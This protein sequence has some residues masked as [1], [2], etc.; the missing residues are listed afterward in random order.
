LISEPGRKPTSKQVQGAESRERIL[1]AAEALVAERG[2]AATSISDVVKASRLPSSSIYWHFSSKEELLGAVVERGAR[3]WLREVPAWT[4]FGGDLDA[5]AE[6]VAKAT[7]GRPA[8]L[9]LLM[10]LCLDAS[11]A[12]PG[13]QAQVRDVWRS[14]RESLTEVMHYRYALPR[15]AKGRKAADRLARFMLASFDGIFIDS[16]I[17]SAG[18]D[19]VRMAADLVVGLDAIAVSLVGT[20][21]NPPSRRTQP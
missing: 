18:T 19:V 12:T 8:F 6:A 17:D 2:Y 4:S 15:T 5:F 21:P 11:G 1:D 7:D 16:H 13:A 14:T 3:R 20:R 10:V 9:R